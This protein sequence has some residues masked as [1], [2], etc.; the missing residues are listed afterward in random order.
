MTIARKSS[1]LA[2]SRV[3]LVATIRAA[4]RHAGRGDL[5]GVVD[6]RHPGALDRRRRQPAGAVHALAEP[7]DLHPPGHV[8]EPDPSG[9]TSAISRRTELVPQSIAATRVTL[10]RSLEMQQHPGVAEGVRLDP[11][12]VEELRDALVVG[13]Q[14]LLVDLVR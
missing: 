10:M 13:A 4:A 11:F 6:Q 8:R 14:Q 3:A 2:A 5:G 7:H 12:Q 1:A 9:W